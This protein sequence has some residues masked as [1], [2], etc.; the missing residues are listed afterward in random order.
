MAINP[1][2]KGVC[3]LAAV[4]QALFY[5]G[6]QFAGSD[7]L[8]L[9]Q[10]K[11]QSVDGPSA[12][13]TGTIQKL[14]LIQNKGGIIQIHT[15]NATPI[16]ISFLTIFNS[17]HLKIIQMDNDDLKIV[18][19]DGVAFE[20]GAIREKINSLLIEL[21]SGNILLDLGRDHLVL[22]KNLNHEM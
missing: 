16:K 8:T 18:I 14:K 13:L 2:T 10:D 11:T 12:S 19:I 17:A 6:N 3:T 4:C 7:L 5:P 9:L 20:S 22:A 21:S 15:T 1:S